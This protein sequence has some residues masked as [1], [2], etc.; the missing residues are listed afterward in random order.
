MVCFNC[1]CYAA[2]SREGASGEKFIR[3]AVN[4][5][6]FIRPNVATHCHSA[7]VQDFGDF[8]LDVNLLLIDKVALFSFPW[9]ARSFDSS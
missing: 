9:I 4:P 2:V 6:R 3:S 8:P 7:A 1:F 5:A